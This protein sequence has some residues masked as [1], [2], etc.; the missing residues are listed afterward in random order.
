MGGERLGA[1]GREVEGEDEYVIHKHGFLI[2]YITTSFKFSFS[3]LVQFL[4]FCV[5]LNKEEKDGA[6]NF[7]L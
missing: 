4:I 7:L 1:G 3:A 2:K 5:L 6:Y